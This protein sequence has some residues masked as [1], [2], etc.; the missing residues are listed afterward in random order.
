MKCS[1]MLAS[2]SK[3]SSTGSYL[4][5]RTYYSV[6]LGVIICSTSLLLTYSKLSFFIKVCGVCPDGFVSFNESEWF[7]NEVFLLVCVIIYN[8][9]SVQEFVS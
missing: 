1:G 5:H 8:P 3:V 9:V 7:C 2:G 6:F 4:Y